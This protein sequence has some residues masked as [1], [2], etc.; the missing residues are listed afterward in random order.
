[1][2]FVSLALLQ[3][4]CRSHTYRLD[5]LY[6]RP[7]I[8]VDTPPKI[9]N[10]HRTFRSIQLHIVEIIVINACDDILWH[11]IR[12]DTYTLYTVHI[13][14]F[15]ERSAL[16]LIAVSAVI[17]NNSGHTRNHL[18]IAWRVGKEH[19]AYHINV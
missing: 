3:I 10:H 9:I 18:H 5:N 15:R 13:I 12:E 1:M 11:V 7:D 6:A 4:S 14:G 19:K 16:F 2:P 17:R 8:R